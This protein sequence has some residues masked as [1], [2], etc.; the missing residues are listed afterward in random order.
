MSPPA[1]G[2][3]VS[4]DGPSGVGK[5]TVARVLGRLLAA[6]G[7]PHR[8]TA[9]PTDSAIG[10]LARC[11]DR[12]DGPTLACLYAADRYQHLHEVIRP[13]VAAGHVVI[14]DRY[15]PSGLVMQR[16]D[17]LTL[18]YLRQ[19]NAHADPADLAVILTGNPTIVAQRLQRRGAHNRYQHQSGST[20][21]ELQLYTDDADALDGTTRVLRLNTTELHPAT[22]ATTIGEHITQLRNHRAQHDDGTSHP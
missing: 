19:V 5:S 2:L 13:A 18:D 4:I 10:Q 15:L 3:F 7:V 22:V 8:L 12:Y 17:G 9:E 21:T 14:T 16:L 6:R 11:L 1:A 20:A